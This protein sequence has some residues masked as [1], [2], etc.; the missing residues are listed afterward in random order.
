MI[1][2]EEHD[3]QVNLETNMVNMLI[4]VNMFMNANI[5][6]HEVHKIKGQENLK[7]CSR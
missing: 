7:M 5:E 6:K 3:V 4:M 1:I 2:I